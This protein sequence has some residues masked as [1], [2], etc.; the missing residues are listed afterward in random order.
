MHEQQLSAYFWTASHAASEGSVTHSK[1]SALCSLPH[2]S[3]HRSLLLARVAV[4]DRWEWVC[5]P[6][7][8]ARLILLS[9]TS[10]HGMP[11]HHQDSD[12]WYLDDGVNTFLLHHSRLQLPQVVWKKCKCENAQSYAKLQRWDG[13]VFLDSKNIELCPVFCSNICVVSFSITPVQYV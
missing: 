8:R 2:A 6:S 5:C 9:L 1:E 10:G 13:S 7:L 12:L 11:W 3:A 4:I